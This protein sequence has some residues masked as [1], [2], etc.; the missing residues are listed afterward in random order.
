MR[1]ARYMYG[2]VQHMKT[3]LLGTAV[4]LLAAPAVAGPVLES[5][6]ASNAGWSAAESDI[7]EGSETYTDLV[8][9]QDGARAAVL[10]RL[11]LDES[12]GIIA[13]D[14][15]GAVLDPDKD[16]SMTFDAL[17]ARVDRD[18][19]ATAGRWLTE[20]SDMLMS[21]GPLVAEA[22]EKLDAPI[23][24]SM[25]G[26]TIARPGNG[27]LQAENVSASYD[28][29]E[30]D[31]A[32]LL[33]TSLDISGMGITSPDLDIFIASLRGDTL[34]PLMP[35]RT[36][37]GAGTYYSKGGMNG[38]SLSMSGSQ[39]LRIGSISF[40]SEADSEG[41]SALAG[42]GYFELVEKLLEAGE[43]GRTPSLSG[44]DMS[45]PAIW[46]AMR[47]VTVNSEFALRGLEITGSMAMAMTGSQTLSPGRTL[48][49]TMTSGK[50]GPVVWANADI[51]SPG[52]ATLRVGLETVMQEMDPSLASAGPSAFMMAA[53]ISVSELAIDIDDQGLGEILAQETG[54]DVYARAVDA[55]AGMIGQ[56][57]AESLGDWLATAR[58]DGAY[59]AA[60][61]DVPMPIT[62]VFT[63]VMGPWDSFG[64]A[65][66]ATTEK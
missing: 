39:E 59:L 60:A 23:T 10:E 16:T 22:C 42:T 27:S 36:V 46:N 56:A 66:N 2:K 48:D 12:G 8:I 7:S 25:H 24:A 51:R 13:I 53:P 55:T 34:T 49:M 41:V 63:G 58:K 26:L 30:P 43:A 28:I 3:L 20:N 37:D 40:E 19:L 38:L 61:P 57:K 15:G 5:M 4:G 31:G 33:D 18:G 6:L 11:T 47:E 29:A 50:D 17:T 45:L 44:E 35:Q 21:D 64:A 32:C 62:Q 52:L 14:A 54:I 1:N 9:T 65:I